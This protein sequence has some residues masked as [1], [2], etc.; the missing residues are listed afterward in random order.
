M[1]FVNF[2]HV[3]LFLVFPVLV[4]SRDLIK[5]Q[6]FFGKNVSRNDAVYF[7]YYIMN[8]IIDFI[9]VWTRLT[10]SSRYVVMF[11]LKFPNN[12]SANAIV[13]KL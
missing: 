7:M 1:N 12:V 10:L 11:I 6:F 5:V 8:Q 9:F 4:K 13:F 2:K 3:L